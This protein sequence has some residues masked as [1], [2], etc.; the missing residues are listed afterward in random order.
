MFIFS[1]SLNEEDKLERIDLITPEPKTN[2]FEFLPSGG[3]AIKESESSASLQI[4]GEVKPV[5]IP[6]QE[7][8]N[9]LE[10]PVDNDIGILNLLYHNQYEF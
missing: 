2:T 5:V 1:F 4:V 8:Q 3:K 10:E 9:K 7:N 6:F